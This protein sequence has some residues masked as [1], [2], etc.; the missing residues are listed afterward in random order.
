MLIHRHFQS[1]YFCDIIYLT[2][3]KRYVYFARTRLWHKLC[4]RQILLEH[5]SFSEHVVQPFGYASIPVD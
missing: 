1:A 4:Y 3:K 5:L 2:P